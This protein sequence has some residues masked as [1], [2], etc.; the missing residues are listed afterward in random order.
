MMTKIVLTLALV[1]MISVSPAFAA[2]ISV[3]VDGTMKL[4][5]AISYT[6]SGID[7][8]HVSAD[9]ESISMIFQVSVS[10]SVEEG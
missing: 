1:T 7:L 5:N 3:E 6:S 10:N 2:S 4:N 8:E 9:L